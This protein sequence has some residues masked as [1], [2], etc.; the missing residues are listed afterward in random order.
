M[1]L[2]WLRLFENGLF[3][4]AWRFPPASQCADGEALCYS[5]WSGE[6]INFAMNMSILAF[7]TYIIISVVFTVV[8]AT[9][10]TSAKGDI[11]SENSAPPKPSRLFGS[12]KT[13]NLRIY[14]K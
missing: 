2:G 5:D 6:K 13:N 1:F 10:L 3:E 9:F 8:V 4:N 7:L 14:P 12:A 11:K